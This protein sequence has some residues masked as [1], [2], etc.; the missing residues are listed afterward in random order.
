MVF[1][2]WLFE[3]VGEIN[4]KQEQLKS[5][6]ASIGVHTN[7]YSLGSIHHSE[8]VCVLPEAGQWKVFYVE[9]DE[10]KEMASFQ[11]E[12]DAY[13]FIYATFCKWMGVQGT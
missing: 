2:K 13:D 6:L 8:C 1:R 7:S 9:R 3:A 12:E 4:M 11:T 10:P 5:S